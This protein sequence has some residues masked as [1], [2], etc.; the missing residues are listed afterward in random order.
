MVRRAGRKSGILEATVLGLVL[1]GTPSLTPPVTQAAPPGPTWTQL[2]PTGGPPQARESFS[3]VYD[4]S[5]TNMIIF[6]GAFHGA[7][8]YC[9]PGVGPCLNDTWVLTNAGGLGGR[10]P[11]WAQLSPA[12]TLPSA[13][14][15]HSAVYDPNTNRMVVFGGD[16]NGGFCSGAVNDVWVLTSPNGHGPKPTW[17][18]LG[19]TGGPPS[20]RRAHSA[21]YDPATN[22]MI[23]FGG[24]NPCNP[25]TNDVWVLSN[26]NGSGGTPTW[27]QLAPTG[28][29]IPDGRSGHSAVYDPATNRMIVFG[30]S[31]SSG[32]SRRVFTLT[33]ANGSG[34]TPTWTRLTIA[35]GPSPRAL[36]SAVYDPFTNRMTVFGG[37]D[38]NGVLN[39]AWVL[40]NANGLGGTPT[41]TPVVPSPRP[42]A[43]VG[44]SAV[45]NSGTNRMTI[46]GGTANSTDFNDVWA[47]T[48]ANGIL[49]SFT[50]TTVDVPAAVNTSAVGINKQ[51]SIV[52]AYRDTGGKLHGFLDVGGT[53]ST[54]DF[55]DAT[56][57]QIISINKSGQ[58]VGNY[59]IGAS[60]HGFLANPPYGVANFT[61][62]NV[63]F[64][65]AQNTIAHGLNDSGQIVGM[66]KNSGGTNHSFLANFPYGP[67]DFT[68]FNV[69]L[70]CSTCGDG[71]GGIN[72]SGQ[73]VG[74]Y[75]A[76]SKNHGYLDTAGVFSTVD[77]PDA[78][79]GSVAIRINNVGQIVGAYLDANSQ[80]HGFLN[81]SGV[82]ETVDFPGAAFEGAGNPA[83]ANTGAFGINDLGQIVGTY[84]DAGG[85]F[86]GYLATPGS[87][88]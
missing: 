2:T 9:H 15:K 68:S 10:T 37:Q 8:N 7:L 78:N 71:A 83:S 3:A 1:I 29:I 24:D 23:V 33:N 14:Q 46:F 21:V 73:I 35:D 66:W 55:P 51:G 31:T 48:K 42:T 58:I 27:T 86:H 85:H 88:P 6:G 50:F 70:E 38:A 11:T 4:A 87:A 84:L 43:R 61:T 54:I 65:G 22:R 20:A 76:N 59:G 49:L 52:G 80:V 67:T 25:S 5:N 30:G 26:A 44:H 82:I 36:H 40:Q 60:T 47:L 63:P 13:R 77:F 57:T 19:P 72:N 62:I 81:T 69:P 41:W 18:Q 39:D 28:I 74:G 45:Y 34:G 75:F 56:F 16:P 32:L 12:G 64:I 79:N 53:F 17:T